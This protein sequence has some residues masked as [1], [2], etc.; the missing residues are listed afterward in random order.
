MLL[1][2]LSGSRQA[3]RVPCHAHRGGTP[4][5]IEALG[6]GTYR[7][8]ILEEER[9]ES[10]E[11]SEGVVRQSGK[12]GRARLGSQLLVAVSEYQAVPSGS[13]CRSRE[14]AGTSEARARVRG[15]EEDRA[16]LATILHRKHQS[17][18][19]SRCRGRLPAGRSA[20]L[21][22]RPVDS[23]H[24][25]CPTISVPNPF[26]YSTR[27]SAAL[28]DCVL[29]HAPLQSI[30]LHNRPISLPPPPQCSVLPAGRAAPAVPRLLLMPQKSLR[31]LDA[32]LVNSHH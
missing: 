6:G 20:P 4:S 31:C 3:S 27:A 13:A 17:I 28:D 15:R 12:E 9:G 14:A 18:H 2:L 5:A 25:S 21:S 11:A 19:S 10:E 8:L 23:F 16:A 22:P 26:S 24:E 30:P 7:A 29:R 32:A 1:L